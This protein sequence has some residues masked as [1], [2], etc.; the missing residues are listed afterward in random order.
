M[1]VGTLPMP[2][3][4]GRRSDRPLLCEHMIEAL[5]QKRGLP[6]REICP[7]ALQRLHRH[8]WPGNIREL[9]NVLERSLMMSDGDTLTLAEIDA[10][11]V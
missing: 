7:E 2:P 1:S 6:L 4:R 5:C 8:N 10:R 11:C 9:Q 3:L